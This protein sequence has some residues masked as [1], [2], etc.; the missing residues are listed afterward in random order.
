MNE[1]RATNG[2]IY[3]KTHRQTHRKVARELLVKHFETEGGRSVGRVGG[4]APWASVRFCLKRQREREGEEE[5]S[6]GSKPS[7]LLE[8]Q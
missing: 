1:R 8:I 5:S 3:N 4:K 7:K 2:N 6:G